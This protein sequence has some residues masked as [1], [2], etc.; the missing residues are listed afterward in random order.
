MDN[1]V[2]NDGMKAGNCWACERVYANEYRPL[3]V[4]RKK[5]QKKL[6]RSLPDRQKFQK[7]RRKMYRMRRQGQKKWKPVATQKSLSNIV[8]QNDRLIMPEDEFWLLRRYR[9]KFGDPKSKENKARG[10]KVCRKHGLKGVV[11]PGDDG[12]GPFRLQRSL[13]NS[14]EKRETLAE[15][16]SDCSDDH[17]DNLFEQLKDDRDDQHASVAQ[18]MIAALLKSHA[19]NEEEELPKKVKKKAKKKGK[20]SKA[21]AGS[22]S[23]SSSD[24]KAKKRGLT[25][26]ES[27]AS[28]WSDDPIM[29]RR[30]RVRKGGGTGKVGSTQSPKPSATPKGHKT[31]RGAVKGVS[32]PTHTQAADEDS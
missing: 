28:T 18:G 24:E 10:H 20:T 25:R 1:R 2:G 17:V 7:Q 3:G 16:N 32:V 30:R 21:T 27:N 5:L 26:V 11:V 29:S 12:E 31:R 23:D 19:Q 13:Q 8:S 4:D 9:K 6:S 22:G 15:D 14:L